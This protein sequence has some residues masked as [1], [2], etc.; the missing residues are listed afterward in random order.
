M[1]STENTSAS[2][3]IRIRDHEDGQAW[4]EFAQVYTPLVYSY[5]RRQGL[6]DTDAF[7]VT[8]D[9]LTTVA[10]KVGDF[11]YDRGR[12]SFRGWLR[13][14]TRSRLCDFIDSNKR[15]LQGSGDTGVHQAIAS[16]QLSNQEDE[17]WELECRRS[18]FN[19]AV[20]KIRGEFRDPTWHSFWQTAVE[21]KSSNDTAK[22]L[23]MSVGAVYVARSRV[24]AR[25]KEVVQLF[26]D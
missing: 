15:H 11:Q 24:L 21:G 4:A 20:T 19:W 10:Q 26:E 13:A 14:V 25:L 8:Q 23:T 1:G 3:L 18:A 2:L 6:Q 17:L 7:T 22:S 9:V 12:G 16:V 5:A